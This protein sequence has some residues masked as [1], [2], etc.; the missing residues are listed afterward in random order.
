M[1]KGTT[2]P[3]H[4]LLVG[5][6]LFAVFWLNVA[7]NTLPANAQQ[8]ETAEP[9]FLLSYPGAIRSESICLAEYTG[10]DKSK[11]ISWDHP[12]QAHY[13]ITEI[14]KGPPFGRNPTVKYEFHDSIDRTMPNGWKFSDKMMPEKDSKWILFIEVAVPKRGMLELYQGSYGR[15]PATDENLKQL[16]GL[17]DKYNMRNTHS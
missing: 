12:P 10:Y 13:R 5:V 2:F 15:Q 17:L 3:R 8:R 4:G 16:N 6:G 11:D 7:Q 1:L 14:L 9:C